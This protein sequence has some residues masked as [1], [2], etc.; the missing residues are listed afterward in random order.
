MPTGDATRRTY[1]AAHELADNAARQIHGFI[2][3]LETKRRTR[4]VRE[5]R[6]EYE[7]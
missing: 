3:Y 2:T 5:G 6:I 1:T 4:R 7:I